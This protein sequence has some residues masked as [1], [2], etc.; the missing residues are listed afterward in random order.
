MR[1]SASKPIVKRYTSEA[2]SDRELLILSIL[3]LNRMDP[4][5]IL[6]EGM[7]DD[8]RNRLR[9]LTLL[10]RHTS[11]PAIPLSTVR[12]FNSAADWILS[13]QPGDQYYHLGRQWLGTVMYVACFSSL[14]VWI[15]HLTMRF[16]IYSP[17]VLQASGSALLDARENFEDQRTC[18]QL[19]L[20][21]VNYYGQCLDVSIILEHYSITT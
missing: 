12:S 4:R 8:W 13:L 18:T 2:I 17:I 5:F 21:W 15:F 11:D 10:I 19:A 14:Y 6:I 16:A 9:D 7:S 3:A 20:S 1:R